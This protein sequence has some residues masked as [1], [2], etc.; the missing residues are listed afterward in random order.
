MSNQIDTQQLCT[1]YYFS[2]ILKISVTEPFFAVVRT[3]INSNDKTFEVV[4][5]NEF[6][7]EIIALNFELFGI[8]WLSDILFSEN[9]NLVKLSSEITFTKSLIA[10]HNVLFNKMLLWE[11]MGYYN[12][13]LFECQIRNPSADWGVLRDSMEL[14]DYYNNDLFNVS[15]AKSFSDFTNNETI[16]LSVR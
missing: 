5:N 9:K 6:C 12:R 13:E 8:A 16:T 1:D 7:Y 15:L 3:E 11:R 4:D 14:A 10:Q 2:Q